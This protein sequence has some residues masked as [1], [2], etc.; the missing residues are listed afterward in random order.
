MDNNDE[1]SSCITHVMVLIHDSLRRT[2]SSKEDNLRRNG[3]RSV[4]AFLLSFELRP[5]F[6]V[7]R[8][9]NATHC[10]AIAAQRNIA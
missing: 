7:T 8:A 10:F 4:A 6:I 9:I 2:R 5:M 1:D 3:A